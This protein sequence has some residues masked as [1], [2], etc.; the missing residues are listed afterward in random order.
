MG[1]KTLIFEGETGGHRIEFIEYL[2]LNLIN[3]PELKS[4]YVFVL[5]SKLISEIKLSNKMLDTISIIELS[6]NNYSSNLF[7]RSFQQ[8]K[9]IKQVL[10]SDSTIGRILFMNI[11]MFQYVILSPGFLKYKLSVVGILFQPYTQIPVLKNVGSFFGKNSIRKFRKILTIGAIL[12]FQQN[13]ILHILNDENAVIELNK[14]HRRKKSAFRNLPD[15]IDDRLL[16]FENTKEKVCTRYRIEANR[17]ILLVFGGIDDRKNIK[18]IIESLILIT[19]ELQSNIALLIVGK[20]EPGQIENI[21]A[22][23]NKALDT[24]PNLQIVLHDGFVTNF[25]R[26][27]IFKASD[28]VLIPY[29]NF[30]SSSGVVGHAAKYNKKVI[31]SSY[32]IIKLIT[33]KYL[34]GLSV[35]PYD[36][37]DIKNGIEKL[38][39]DNVNVIDVNNTFLNSH[40]HSI[41]SDMLL[42]S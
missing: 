4:N 31:V 23:K 27:E 11:D 17:N 32:G 13:V 9:C 37:I 35:D 36:P 28:I 18:R 15:P 29:I 19:T 30:Y 38:L 39:T 33:E 10:K 34:L 21:T 40:K 16:I 20:F 5:N 14:R 8:W 22:Y 6:I 3:N 41:F 26:E 1:C 7:T 25:E 2:M 42:S 12:Q 24:C